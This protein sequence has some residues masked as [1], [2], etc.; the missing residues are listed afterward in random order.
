MRMFLKVSME[1]ETANRAIKD[2]SLPKIVEGFAQTF[3]PEGMWFTA[4][5]GKRCMIA[6]F[7]LASTTQIP[8]LAEPFFAGVGAAIELTPAM[9]ISDL[10]T[11][12]TAL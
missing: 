5:D 1:V 11:G 12:L 7:D 6:I 2:G 4:L 8:K 3:K 9:D 10:R